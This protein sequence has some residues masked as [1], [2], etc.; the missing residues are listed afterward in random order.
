MNPSNYNQGQKFS[1]TA[2][3]KK[4]N[5]IL[6]LYLRDKLLSWNSHVDNQNVNIPLDQI[7][8][9]KKATKEANQ[10]ELLFLKVYANEKGIVFS[11]SGGNN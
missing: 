1:S 7:I 4:K 10:A 2:S 11:F 8:E 5:G 6:T 9:I 3:Y